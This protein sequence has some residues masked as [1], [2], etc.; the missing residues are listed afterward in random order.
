MHGGEHITGTQSRYVTFVKT[1][2]YDRSINI[3]LFIVDINTVTNLE[4]SVDIV[5][6]LSEEWCLFREL[7]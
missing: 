2:N 1:S 7:F 4:E 6:S 5:S 3:P